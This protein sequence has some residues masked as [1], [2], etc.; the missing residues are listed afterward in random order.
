MLGDASLTSAKIAGVEGGNLY[1]IRMENAA[2]IC[3]AARDL[4]IQTH[5]LSAFGYED[6]E[7][8]QILP[9]VVEEF[10]LLYIIPYQPCIL[11]IQNIL[12]A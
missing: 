6:K 1:D 11:S 3:K 9:D 2:I 7:Y 10:R 5:N 8:F 4:V 12:I